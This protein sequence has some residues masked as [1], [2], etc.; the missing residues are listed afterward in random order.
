MSSKL[1]LVLL[2]S[3]LVFVS[4]KYGHYAQHISSSIHIWITKTYLNSTS[5]LQD[6]F[7]EYFNQ[8]D[9]IV[10]LRY[11]NE[12]L[13]HLATLSASFASK[14]NAF[15]IDE[16]SKA[17][18][19]KVKLVRALSYSNLS[20][21][22]RIWLDFPDFNK[23]KIYGLMY[24]GNTA[25]IIVSNNDKPLGL[26][27]GDFKCTFS[28]AVGKNLIPGVAVGNAKQI[29]IKYIPRWMNPKIGDK[30]IT[31]GLDN[32]FFSGIPVGEV[33]DV[34]DENSYLKAVVKPHVKPNIPAFFYAITKP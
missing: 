10:K 27:Q 19:P 8:K 28:V 16:K 6:K 14:L 26:L 9:E 34:V 5:Y 7:N 2:L 29:D 22:N 3:A 1:K 17:Y 31:S 32:I 11:E 12:K 18:E 33:I 23:S 25:G 4:L 21:Y 30:V 13:K 20:N 24:E 15:L